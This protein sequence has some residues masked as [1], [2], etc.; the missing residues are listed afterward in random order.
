MLWG[1]I[2]QYWTYET[3]MLIPLKPEGKPPPRFT[4]TLHTTYLY[5]LSFDLS[6]KF[7]MQN[8]R[9]SP[10]QL[11]CQWSLCSV[12]YSSLMAPRWWCW[13]WR[14]IWYKSTAHGQPKHSLICIATTQTSHRHHSSVRWHGKK[15]ACKK[16]KASAD[17]IGQKFIHFG[18]SLLF[19]WTHFHS[20]PS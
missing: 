11:F 9:K 3:L 13:W 15:N 17:R 19:R 1:F 6:A 18:S 4:P 2:I 10:A 5:Q 16:L 7:V 14:C 12:F 20:Q 8:H